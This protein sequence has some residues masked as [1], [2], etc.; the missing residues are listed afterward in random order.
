MT[1][2]FVL[3]ASMRTGS[4]LL[5][6]KL[7]QFSGVICHGEAFNPAFV[8][9]ADKHL[10]LL[11]IAREETAVRDRDPREFLAKILAMDAEAVG[12]HMFPDHAPAI[13]QLLLEDRSVKKICLRRSIIHSFVSL[14]VAQRTD[15]W[16]VTKEGPR[17]ELTLADKQIVF[18]PEEFERYRKKVDRFWHEVLAQLSASGQE[19]FP[20]W[21]REIGRLDKLNELAGFLGIKER[22]QKLAEKL[23]RQNPEQLKEIVQN[24]DE[25]VAYARSVKLDHQI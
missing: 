5:N 3:L 16:R 11:G 10:K 14:Q 22:K 13:L 9:L 12:L 8:G 7:N 6:S 24:W 17:R 18:R 19:F 20:I 25:M 2:R 23:E 4:N 21:Y 15:V 1:V